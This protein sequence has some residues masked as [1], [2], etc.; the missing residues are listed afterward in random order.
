MNPGDRVRTKE[1]HE[2][3]TIIQVYGHHVT[4]W[5]DT[6]KDYIFNTFYDNEIEIIE[7][8]YSEQYGERDQ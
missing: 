4:I 1:D 6:F 5:L 7:P 3:G 8:R 2:Y